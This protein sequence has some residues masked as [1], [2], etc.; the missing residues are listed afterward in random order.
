MN[1]MLIAACDTDCS[2]VDLI[3][4]DANGNT[5]DSDFE[6]DDFPIVSTTPGRDGVYRLE[7]QMVACSAN[8]CR[9]AIQQFVK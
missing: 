1:S 8:P 6:L 4:Y 9:Y 2:D 7:V 3:L 5:V